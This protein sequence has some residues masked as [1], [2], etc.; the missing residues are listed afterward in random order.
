MKIVKI[1]FNKYHNFV[2]FLFLM[3]F[4]K[5][6]IIVIFLLT[7]TT[8]MLVGQASAN[9]VYGILA[10]KHGYKL[11]LILSVLLAFL[12]VCL[13]LMISDPN[14]FYLVFVL[15]GMSLSGFFLAGMIVYEF[16]QADVRPTYVGLNNTWLG[17]MSMLAPIVGGVIAQTVGY[18]ALFLSGAVLSLLGGIVIVTAVR[19]PRH[20]TN[21][22]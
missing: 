16:S 22:V 10:D 9:L 17:T 1:I 21:I 15:R 19:D 3:I 12:A 14:W 18:P 5:Y 6:E 2:N 11:I 4:R 7:F 8:A 13:P 20:T